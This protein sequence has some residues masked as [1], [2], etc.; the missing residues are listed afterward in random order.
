M[1][2]NQ[3]IEFDK[4]VREFLS[5]DNK[6]LLSEI[7]DNLNI[8]VEFKEST[9]DSCCGQIKKDPKTGEPHHAEVY[10]LTPLVQSKIAHEL[11]HIK[12][13][14]IL[15]DLGCILRLPNMTEST[16]LLFAIENLANLN[17]IFDHVIFRNQMYAMG[18]SDQESFEDSLSKNQLKQWLSQVLGRSMKIKGV[19]CQDFLFAY[20]S[21]VFT[22]RFY[23]NENKYKKELSELKKKDSHIFQIIESLYMA[24]AD[25]EIIAE[26]KEKVQEAY[27]TFAENMN[28]ELGC[29]NI[30]PFLILRNM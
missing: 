11:L 18:Y 10:Y 9:G 28:Q 25:I 30:L 2:D 12:V 29:R 6:K 24:I 23:P 27:Y 20:M 17:N 4:K 26:N 15:G 22:L 8:P 5:E 16:S 7:E 19:Y 14:V 3:N 21:I 1:D 13:G